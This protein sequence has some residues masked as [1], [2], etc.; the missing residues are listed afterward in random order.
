MA[1]EGGTG[2][3]TLDFPVGRRQAWD[4]RPEPLEIGLG[5]DIQGIRFDRGQTKGSLPRLETNLHGEKE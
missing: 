2:L 3:V 4:C 1:E 5:D